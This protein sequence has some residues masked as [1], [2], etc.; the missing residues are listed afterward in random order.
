MPRR[1]SSFIE[2][3][4]AEGCA[5]PHVRHALS[6][7]TGDVRLLENDTLAVAQLYDGVDILAALLAEG[8]ETSDSMPYLMSSTSGV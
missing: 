5:G 1:Q 6:L 4:G 2:G 7:Y 3:S 8:S